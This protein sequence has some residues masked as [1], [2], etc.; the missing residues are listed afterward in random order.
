ISADL[1]V[2]KIIQETYDTVYTVYIVETESYVGKHDQ[3]AQ[4]FNGRKNKSLKSFY[5]EGG[6]IYAHSIHKQ[7]LI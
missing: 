5:C 1:L 6:T 3:D 7:L 4:S 2:V